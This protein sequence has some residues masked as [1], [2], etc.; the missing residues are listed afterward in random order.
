MVLWPAPKCSALNLQNLTVKMLNK[1][2]R[3]TSWATVL[4]RVVSLGSM[5]ATLATSWKTA[6]S[7]ALKW[8]VSGAKNQSA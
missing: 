4:T 5:D 7:L 3:K 6:L 1:A 2:A 8:P